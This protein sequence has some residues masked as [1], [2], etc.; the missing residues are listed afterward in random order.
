[1]NK[2]FLES[3]RLYPQGAAQSPSKTVLTLLFIFTFATTAHAAQGGVEALLA[4]A[5]AEVARAPLYQSGYYRGGYPPENIGVCTDLLWR[6]FQDAGVELKN[7]IDADIKANPLAYPRVGGKPDR[8]IDFRRVP[9]HSAFF[10]RHSASLTTLMDVSK[11]ESLASWQ[12]GDIAVFRNPDIGIISDKK[13]RQG[14]PYLIH[15]D[16]PWPREDDDF[17]GWYRRGIVGHYRWNWK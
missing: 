6:A 2:Y 10:K 9:N 13:N 3:S 17:M 7:L 11:P 1:M 15:N 16:G 14:V 8:N 4:G 5:R 12:P